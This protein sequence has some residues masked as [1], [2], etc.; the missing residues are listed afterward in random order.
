MRCPD[1]GAEIVGGVAPFGI[2]ADAAHECDD[3]TPD[4]TLC[5]YPGCR[6]EIG[7]SDRM[8]LCHGQ[9]FCCFA[10][11]CLWR[12]GDEKYTDRKVRS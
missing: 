6:R 9:T 12:P 3:E 8:C 10:C 5:A 7:I 2:E 4:V 11:A 1:C